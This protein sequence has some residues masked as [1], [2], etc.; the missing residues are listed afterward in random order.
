MVWKE[1]TESLPWS[2]RCGLSSIYSSW[3][4]V[5]FESHERELLWSEYGVTMNF[6]TLEFDDIE[7]E[8]GFQADM[9]RRRIG[10]GMLSLKDYLN[11]GSNYLGSGAVF[12]LFLLDPVHF[13]AS[14]RR[15]RES[16]GLQ[17]L[18]ISQVFKD[19]AIS[20]FR[21]LLSSGMAGISLVDVSVL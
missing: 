16:N 8:R 2:I 7:M 10:N 20:S 12:D 3:D 17:R 6:V 18:H 15:L 13:V 4:D 21:L 14:G 1:L 11:L 9:A 5:P 19:R